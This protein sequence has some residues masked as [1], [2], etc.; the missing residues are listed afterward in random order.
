MAIENIEVIEN[1]LLKIHH[2]MVVTLVCLR[3]GKTRIKTKRDPFSPFFDN[4]LDLCK[5]D[6]PREF[7]ISHFKY[8]DESVVIEVQKKIQLEVNEENAKK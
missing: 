3:F 7:R 1:T 8:L 6:D 4:L 5:I 2:A